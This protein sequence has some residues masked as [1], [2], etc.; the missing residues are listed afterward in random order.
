MPCGVF[1]VI[2]WNG[3]DFPGFRVYVTELSKVLHQE[4]I[5]F[6]VVIAEDDGEDFIVAWPWQGTV[7]ECFA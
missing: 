5:V 3:D 2:P 1:Q 7:L 6:R 4:R